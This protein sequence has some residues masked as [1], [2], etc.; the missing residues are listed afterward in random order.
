MAR[1]AARRAP[2]LVLASASPR[3]KQILKHAGIRYCV[4]VADIPEQP[5][6]DEAP[7]ACV[8][9]LAREK[10]L[11]VK[12]AGDEIVLAADTVVVVDGRILGKP[13]NA[14]DAREM[15]RLLSGREHEVV[16]GICLKHPSG[17]ITDA[18][19][20]LVRFAV[21]SE[22]EIADYVAGGEPMDKAGAYAIQGAASKFIDR[23]E[24][25]YFNVVGLPVALV[26]K[27]LEALAARPGRFPG[28][29]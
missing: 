23:I 25:C 1:R 16:T 22:A 17:T 2:R 24:G 3:R 15:L 11:A 7:E 26:R 27:H 8:R 28:T 5:L 9:R 14:A 18:E 4:R 21:L 6:K 13:A 10:A 12:A 29:D 20:T 19:R